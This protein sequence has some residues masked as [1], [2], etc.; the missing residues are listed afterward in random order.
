[1]FLRDLG[2]KGNTISQY[3][4]H[5]QKYI[6]LE[7]AFCEEK[8]PFRSSHLA[9]LIRHFKKEDA[10]LLSSR[11]Q[12]KVAV[13]FPLYVK[14]LDIISQ[15]NNWSVQQRAMVSAAWATGYIFSLRPSEYLK[16]SSL[17]NPDHRLNSNS[18]FF[19]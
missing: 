18:I 5:V 4:S 9:S 3:I 11:T 13:I 2:L 17:S 8:T 19:G 16:M 15:M 6:D 7:F 14:G 10:H 1:M 12:C